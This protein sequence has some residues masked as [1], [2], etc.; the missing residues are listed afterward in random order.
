MH[1]IRNSWKH[2]Y[3][4]IYIYIY[5]YI[6]IHIHVYYKKHTQ[7]KYFYKSHTYTKKHIGTNFAC[8]VE[9]ILTWIPM[10]LLDILHVFLT[11]VITDPKY[12]NSMVLSCPFNSKFWPRSWIKSDECCQGVLLII[13][14]SINRYYKD[15][16]RLYEDYLYVHQS[17]I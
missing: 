17:H 14:M 13:Q 1:D 6:H 10:K 11:P 5:I 8:T 2:S 4:S 3:S 9:L 12:K 16:Y 7:M 15:K